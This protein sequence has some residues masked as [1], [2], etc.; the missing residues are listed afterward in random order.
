YSGYGVTGNTFYPSIA[1]LGEF[2][3]SYTFVDSITNCSNQ[4][5]TLIKVYDPIGIEELENSKVKLFPNPGT[6]DFVLTGTNLQSVQIKTLA[7]KLIKEVVIKDR[8]EIHFNLK[9]QAKGFYFVHI[10]ND[11]TQIRRLLILL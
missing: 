9:G 5:S 6:G 4:D 7:G 10:V 3:I 8:S 11:N 1:G 2:W